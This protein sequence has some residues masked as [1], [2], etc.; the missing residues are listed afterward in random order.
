MARPDPDDYTRHE[1]ANRCYEFIDLI[2]K[3]GRAFQQWKAEF[4]V[5]QLVGLRGED[6][7][8]RIENLKD[9]FSAIAGEKT[10]WQVDEALSTPLHPRHELKDRGVLTIEIRLV[11]NGDKEYFLVT[12]PRNDAQGNLQY[13]PLKFVVDQ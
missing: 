9:G 3:N 8:S 2:E 4:S 11:A 10:G 6:I 1:L 12:V 7:D 5:D 13:H